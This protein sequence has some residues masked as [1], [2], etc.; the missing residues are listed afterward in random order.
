MHIAETHILDIFSKCGLIW[1]S[2][3]N[4]LYFS[5]SLGGPLKLLPLLFSITLNRV[6]GRGMV[7]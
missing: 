2:K 7:D 4:P 1:L 3:G 5:V 6:S